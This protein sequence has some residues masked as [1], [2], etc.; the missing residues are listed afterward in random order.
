MQIS[1]FVSGIVFSAGVFY[2]TIYSKL[3]NQKQFNSDVIK[4]LEAI[5]DKLD[6]VIERVAKMEG[7][8]CN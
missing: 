8:I 4:R 5:E 7:K 3:N 6:M 1:I 2:G